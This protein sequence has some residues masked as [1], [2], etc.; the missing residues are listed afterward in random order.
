MSLWL[1]NGGDQ[2]MTPDYKE[3]AAEQE[4]KIRSIKEMLKEVM[5]YINK[6]IYSAKSGKVKLK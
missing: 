2:T 1:P 6:D 3:L 4:L 5:K